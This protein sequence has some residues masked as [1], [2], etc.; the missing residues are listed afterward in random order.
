ML[1]SIS[2]PLPFVPILYGSRQ[3]FHTT[4][5]VRTELMFI[6]LCW[7]ANTDTLDFY[8]FNNLLIGMNVFARCKFMSLSI[9]EM[10]LLRYINLSTN[11]REMSFSED[12]LSFVCIEID[13]NTCCC[14]LQTML[15]QFLLRRCI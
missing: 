3:L 15:E 9:D 10:L 8:M 7:S 11:F 1:T 5:S 4:S 6:R 14:L 13:I 12:L 2:L